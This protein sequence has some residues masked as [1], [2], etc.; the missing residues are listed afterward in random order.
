MP[1]TPGRHYIDFL[2]FDELNNKFC[3]YMCQVP[4][5]HSVMFNCFHGGS[6]GVSVSV[7][8]VTPKFRTM[9]TKGIFFDRGDDLKATVVMLQSCLATY[10]GKGSTEVLEFL[11]ALKSCVPTYKQLCK[12]FCT[13]HDCLEC[14][15]KDVLVLNMF[16]IDN[17]MVG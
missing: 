3:R 10:S 5:G 16:L 17:N 15:D 8:N 2:A 13:V 4:F 1:P 9:G 12:S 11:K 14:R 6:D 7:G